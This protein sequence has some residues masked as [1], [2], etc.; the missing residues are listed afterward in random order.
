MIKVKILEYEV[1]NVAMD[2]KEVYKEQRW[3]LEKKKRITDAA[4]REKEINNFCKTHDVIDI[5]VNT[6]DAHYHNNG[7]DNTIR[8][9]YT[10]LYKADEN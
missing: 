9:S 6:I 10:I 8:M 5:K 4:T 2:A 3:Y 7:G 1:V